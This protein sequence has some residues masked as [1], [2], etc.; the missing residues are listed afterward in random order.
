MQTSTFPL[1]A[2][3]CKGVYDQLSLAFGSQPTFNKS[4]VTSAWPKEQ[5]LCNG[6]NP[7]SSLALIFAPTLSKCS[8]TSLRPNPFLNKNVYYKKPIW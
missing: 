6:I 4:L 5:A 1:A 3:S 8:T 7:P 2:A